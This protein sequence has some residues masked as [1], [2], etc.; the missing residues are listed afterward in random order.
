ML[1]RKKIYLSVFLKDSVFEK[2][3]RHDAYRKNTV[4]GNAW[5]GIMGGEIIL[6]L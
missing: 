1:M 2:V 3:Q 5:R 4:Y 6:I